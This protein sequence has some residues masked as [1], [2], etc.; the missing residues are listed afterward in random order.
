MQKFRKEEKEKKS[1]CKQFLKNI[2]NSNFSPS[3]HLNPC[4]V[5][6][7]KNQRKSV[8]KGVLPCGSVGGTQGGWYHSGG[9]VFAAHIQFGKR[10]V[11]SLAGCAISRPHIFGSTFI[12]AVMRTFFWRSCSCAMGVGVDVTFFAFLAIFSSRLISASV[13]FT[14][15]S[16]LCCLCF[17]SRSSSL[18]MS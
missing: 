9:G 8:R 1:S 5:L 14:S 16:G 2:Y 13:C 4:T 17:L 6:G 12:R 18:L 7:A 3:P 11:V 15:T 10:Q